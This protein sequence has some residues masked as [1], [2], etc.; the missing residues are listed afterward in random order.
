[1]TIEQIGSIGELVAAIATVATLAYLALQIRQNSALL[2]ASQAS[3]F[4]EGTTQVSVIIASDREAALLFWAGCESRSDLED[5]DRARFDA[6]ITIAF[7]HLRLGFFQ[8]LD[9][10]SEELQ[11]LLQQGA[12]VR[13]WW[14]T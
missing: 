12:G 5:W 8:D 7:Q 2:A 14:S 1:M 11:Q 6:L 10:W 9:G 4:R 3:A 13:E